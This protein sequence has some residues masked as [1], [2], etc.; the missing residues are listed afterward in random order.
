MP[1]NRLAVYFVL[2]TVLLDAIGIGLIMPMM[3]QL[4]ADLG[5]TNLSEAAIW[6]GVLSSIFAVMMFLF[7]PIVGNLSDR[8]GR[9]PILLISLAVM[10]LDY[11][12]MGFA[13]SIWVLF[14]GR[15]LH[16]MTAANNS[17]AAAVIADISKPEDKAANFG[18]MG[19][20][21]G[22]GFIVGPMMGAGLAEW[23][24]RLPFFAA[25]V[26]TLMNGVFGYFVLVETVTG[27]KRRPFRWARANPLGAFRALGALP[28]QMRMML[29]VFFHELGFVVYPAVWA[30]FT[31]ERYGWDVPMIAL[32]FACFGLLM[33]LVQGV[34]IRK[35]IPMFGERKV[36]IF[37]MC[38][39]VIAFGFTSLNPYGWLGFVFLPITALGA[40]VS[41][42]VR[43]LMSRAV[44]DDAQ[45]ELQGI[46]ASIHAMAMIIG[47]LLMTGL[48]SYY[49]A[50]A[51]GV[52]FPGAPFVLSMLC[53]VSALVVFVKVRRR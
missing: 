38:M 30:Y 32:S 3:P 8:F 7:G 4:L 17:T 46:L 11:L 1:T 2:F 9:R 25:A 49:T 48:F 20:A 53:A 12:L 23:G 6:G 39:N 35:L 29:V 40:L 51:T 37:G 5:I 41:P 52:Y 14:I 28:G 47:P 10:F 19:A 50:A 31:I 15:V 43:G 42:S 34:L 18:L 21:F 13:T 45:G 44:P 22:I 33:A 27:E 16:G 36:A 24:V 26:L